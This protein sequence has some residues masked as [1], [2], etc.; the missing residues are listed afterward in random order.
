MNEDLKQA[1]S[2]HRAQTMPQI[3]RGHMTASAWRGF[4]DKSPSAFNLTKDFTDVVAGN[5][6][7]LLFI[8]TLFLGLLGA[9]LFCLHHHR[10]Y[11]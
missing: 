11:M 9:Y 1:K 7:F 8:S 5:R 6:R 10:R 2:S 3:N 4:F